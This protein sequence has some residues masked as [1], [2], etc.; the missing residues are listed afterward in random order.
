MSFNWYTLSPLLKNAGYCVFAL[1]YGEEDTRLIGAPGSTGSGDIKQSA[2][3]LSSFVDR[4]LAATGAG[5][6]DIV[7]HSQGGMMPRWYMK[8]DGGATKVAHLI[9]LSP[10]NHG[11]TLDGLALDPGRT[12]DPHSGSARPSTSRPSDRP[13]CSSSTPAATRCRRP[14]YGDRSPATTRS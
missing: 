11:S 3:Q 12:G 4:V 1:N 14:L 13:S 9:A 8:F 5:K 6:V 7:G 2:L 10:S